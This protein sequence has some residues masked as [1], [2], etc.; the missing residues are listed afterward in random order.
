MQQSVK[1]NTKNALKCSIQYKVQKYKSKPQSVTY[2]RGAGQHYRTPFHLTRRCCCN[3]V[4]GGVAAV[5]WMFDEVKTT[6]SGPRQT[7][8]HSGLPDGYPR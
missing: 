1:Y 3:V 2:D 6:I 8:S 5:H 7:L 4:S